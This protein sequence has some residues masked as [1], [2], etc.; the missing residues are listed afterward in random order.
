MFL[1]ARSQ[2][3]VDLS[4]R[5]RGPGRDEAFPKAEIAPWD[6]GAGPLLSVKPPQSHAAGYQIAPWENDPSPG[7]SPT[8][9]FG[10]YLFDSNQ[11]RSPRSPNFPTMLSRVD[12]WNTGFDGQDRRP[13]VASTTTM[14]SNGS[15]RDYNRMAHKKLNGFFGEEPSSEDNRHY[16]EAPSFGSIASG[17]T[18]DST[19][20]PRA[21]RAGSFKS[22]YDRYGSGTLTP[23]GGPKSGAKTP[24]P[25]SDVT[26][27]L[28]QDHA[29][30]ST[31]MWFPF[32]IVPRFAIWFE[33]RGFQ[34]G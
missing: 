10:G 27:W 29:V 11:D 26:P 4:P 5:A 23:D 7:L 25:S 24:Q 20:R 31:R 16:S 33:S 22:G 6:Q 1:Y 32:V 9:S 2:D 19:T 30:S 21:S 12:T 13:S 8:G 17:S 28:F 34:W 18:L 14:S 15:G 3:E